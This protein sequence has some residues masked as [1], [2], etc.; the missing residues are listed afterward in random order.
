MRTISAR[1]RPSAWVVKSRFGAAVA[2]LCTGAGVGLAVLFK[3]NRHWKENLL[4][5]AILYVSAV[6]T[7]LVCGAVF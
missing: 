7:G 3:Y 6:A 1:P 5:A 4:L 2:G